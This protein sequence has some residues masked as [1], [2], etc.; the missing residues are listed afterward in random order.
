MRRIRAE[1]REAFLFYKK[2][3]RRNCQKGKRDGNNHFSL[4]QCGGYINCMRDQQ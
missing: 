3:R 4:H 1:P 2:L